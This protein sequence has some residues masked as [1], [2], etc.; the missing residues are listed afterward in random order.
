MR[1]H[2]DFPLRLSGEEMAKFL[3][4]TR[5]RECVCGHKYKEHLY[6]FSIDTSCRIC[7]CPKFIWI[8]SPE[9]PSTSG[10]ISENPTKRYIN[11]QD[12]NPKNPPKMWGEF[13]K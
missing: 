2:I 3:E 12:E 10:I 11:Y 1:K 7:E 9:L 4:K 6:S 8:E 5:N 13:W